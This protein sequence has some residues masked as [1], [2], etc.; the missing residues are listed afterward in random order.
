M[1]D[2]T[3]DTFLDGLF[4]KFAKKQAPATPQAYTAKP[5]AGSV[6]VLVSS[7]GSVEIHG[8]F[9]SL[10]VNGKLVRFANKP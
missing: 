8:E 3:V 6:Y 7:D 9:K 4:S 1:P 5:K 10:T 2:F